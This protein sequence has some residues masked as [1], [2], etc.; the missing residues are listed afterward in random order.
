MTMPWVANQRQTGGKE[1]SGRMRK[2]STRKT[3]ESSG[4][5][6]IIQRTKA[7]YGGHDGGLGALQSE[8]LLYDEHSLTNSPSLETKGFYSRNC[9]IVL[10]R[11]AVMD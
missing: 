8:H 9:A 7:L 3:E 4:R 6:P 11:R 2:E 10:A 5:S 1:N